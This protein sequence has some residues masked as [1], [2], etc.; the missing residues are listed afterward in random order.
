MNQISN[1]TLKQIADELSL[2]VNFMEPLQEFLQKTLEGI[3]KQKTQIRTLEYTIQHKL[4]GVDFKAMTDSEKKFY[5]PDTGLKLT[6]GDLL[7]DLTLSARF[8][9]E[10]IMQMRSESAF[11]EGK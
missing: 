7:R 1:E 10:E 8:T 9:D 11:S 5:N 2:K 4:S 3:K 6:Y